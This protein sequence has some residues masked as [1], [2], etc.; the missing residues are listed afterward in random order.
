MCPAGKRIEKVEASLVGSAKLE[1]AGITL[2]TCTAGSVKITEIDEAHNNK[3]GTASVTGT[4]TIADLTW[5]QAGTLC[6]SPT[7]TVKGGTIHATEGAEAGSI[8]ITATEAEVTI[9]NV[10]VG[11]CTYGVG[12]GLDLGTVKAG[13]NELVINKEVNK[14]AGGSACPTPAV[15]NATYKI[16]NHTAAYYIT[17]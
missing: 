2:D 5:G 8:T 1:G 15:W 14:T 13:G 9:N 11:S 6:S 17:N 10:L 4:I 3:T 12:A 7:T 16:T